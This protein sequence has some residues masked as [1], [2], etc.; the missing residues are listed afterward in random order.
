LCKLVPCLPLCCVLVCVPSSSWWSLPNPKRLH[1]VLPPSSPLYTLTFVILLLNNCRLSNNLTLQQTNSTQNQ[2]KNHSKW[3]RLSLSSVVTPRS[4]APSSS[5][6]SP[7]P[8]P[9]R[10]PGTSPVTTPT[11]SVACTS[12]PLVTT[13]TAALLPA[14][15]STPTTRV[16]APPKT[17]TATSV[18][19][20][21]LRPMLRATPRA[22]SPTSTS[23]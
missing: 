2:D 10:S 21:T 20:A 11:P 15:T 22:P 17:R 8:L 13:P 4:P 16:T 6:R 5:S 18:T 23:S 9:P 1:K 19:L 3:S 14:L 12:T 7:S